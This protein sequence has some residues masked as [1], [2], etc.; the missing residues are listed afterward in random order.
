MSVTGVRVIGCESDWVIGVIRR[1]I[2]VLQRG[3]SGREEYY[4]TTVC[5]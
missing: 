3:V 1:E 4:S 5:V 2:E